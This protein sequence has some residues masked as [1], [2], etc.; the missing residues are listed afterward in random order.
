[1]VGMFRTLS[2]ADSIS[3]AL[4]KLLQRRQE[5]TQAVYKFATKGAGG[6]NIKDQV[7]K[8]RNLVFCVWEDASL[9]AH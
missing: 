2:Q 4:R 8:L 9:W 6:L 3:V 1:M 5:G 7:I